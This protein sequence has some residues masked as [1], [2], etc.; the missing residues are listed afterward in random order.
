VVIHVRHSQSGSVGFVELW[1]DGLRQT[2]ANGASRVYHRTLFDAF[3]SPKLGYDRD[4]AHTAQGVVYGD[5][6]VVGDS[7]GAVGLPWQS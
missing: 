7:A 5:G 6:F 4:P 2:M 3:N 1:V